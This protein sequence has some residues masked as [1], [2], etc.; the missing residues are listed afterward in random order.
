MTIYETQKDIENAILF[1]RKV[2]EAEPFDENA[3][4]KLMTFYAGSGRLSK[5]I[6][7]YINYEKMVEQMDC[8]VSSDIKNLYRRLIQKTDSI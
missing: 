6:K 7:M 4:K 8:P 3:F 1:T 2:L 5:I